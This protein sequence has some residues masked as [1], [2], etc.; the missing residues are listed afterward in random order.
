V[1]DG[2]QLGEFVLSRP[3]L[4]NGSRRVEDVVKIEHGDC[5]TLTKPIT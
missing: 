5:E 3:D 1:L 4:V 2:A